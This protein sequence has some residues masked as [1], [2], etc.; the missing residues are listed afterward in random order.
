MKRW[1]FNILAALS[2]GLCVIMAGFWLRSYW[3]ED[4]LNW[5]FAQ[6]R[7][8]PRVIAPDP[9]RF[10]IEAE[11]QP[12]GPAWVIHSYEVFSTRGSLRFQFDS[13]QLPSGQTWTAPHHAWSWY[14]TAPPVDRPCGTDFLSRMGIAVGSFATPLGPQQ[15]MRGQW[16]AIPH[17][18]VC[19]LTTLLPAW[20]SFRRLRQRHRIARRRKNGLC[21]NCGYD[22][23]ASKERCPECG[24]P[25]PPAHTM[26]PDTWQLRRRRRRR[27]L[28]A[29]PLLA[30]IAVPAG[31][32]AW[33]QARI[34]YWQHLC[35][36]YTVPA[37]AVVYEDGEDHHAAVH[38]PDCWRKLSGT[39]QQDNPAK[40][41]ILFLHE[42]RTPQGRRF[43]AIIEDN[44]Y[45][46]FPLTY[47]YP[48]RFAD[49][50][51]PASLLWGAALYVED[52]DL[53]WGGSFSFHPRSPAAR[54][55]IYA[56]QVDAADLSHFTIR[57]LKWGQEDI[58]DGRL[59]NTGKITLQPRKPPQPPRP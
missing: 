5:Y 48:S 49:V 20:W 13:R 54:T 16:L 9:Y 59:D 58:L 24:K 57:Y 56:G 12:R 38:V 11:V 15:L 1:L 40:G 44:P 14:S 41:S 10:G 31:L 51:S 27:L 3:R 6:Q 42:L 7:S 47:D 53:P 17:W 29:L 52:M 33:R 35:M 25:V 26:T 34:L 21:L 19:A 55:R 50:L 45:M 30:L 23:R 2:L 28:V 39:I 43:L 37:D 8:P 36:R 18:L 32:L 46:D 4:T 22:L